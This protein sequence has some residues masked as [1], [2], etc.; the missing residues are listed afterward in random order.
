MTRLFRHALPLGLCRSALSK[1]VS[2]LTF[3]RSRSDER[4]GCVVAAS[5]SFY[6]TFQ[7]ATVR[8]RNNGR[9]PED[10]QDTTVCPAGLS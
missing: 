1:K 6:G 5:L 9:S 8:G 4:A 2:L 3:K 7:V 10:S